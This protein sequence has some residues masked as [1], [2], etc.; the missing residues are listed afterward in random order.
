MDFLE[1][2]GTILGLIYIWLSIKQKMALWIVGLTQSVIYVYIFYHSQLYADSGLSLY[3]VFASIYGWIHWH[4][5][6]KIIEK[7]QIAISTLQT[8]DWLLYL[9]ITL[10]ITA[11]LYYILLNVPSLLG[12]QPSAF[13]F[14]DSLI[15]AASLVATWM[16]A[17]KILEQWLW[18]IVIDFISLIVFYL[19]GLYP[20]AGLF[21][22]YTIMAV[23]GYLEWRNSLQKQ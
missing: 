9:F 6:N 23:F 4:K 22:I 11:P 1:I 13:P 20:T 3:Y 14:W 2:T 12:W 21:A 8:K 10:S 16:L 17:R 18:W 15:T 5:N 7:E 19:K